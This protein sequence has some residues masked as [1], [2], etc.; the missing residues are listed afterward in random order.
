MQKFSFSPRTSLLEH[1]LASS[2]SS[3]GVKS[4]GSSL[5]KEEAISFKPYAVEGD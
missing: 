3:S 1:L 5:A 2:S 4:L